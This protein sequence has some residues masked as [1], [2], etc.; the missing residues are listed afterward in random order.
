MT[1]SDLQLELEYW[2]ETGEFEED[3]LHEMK[4]QDNRIFLIEPKHGS[5]EPGGTR[6]VTMTYNHMLPG[7]DRLPVLLK[8]AAGREI[9]VSWQRA[10]RYW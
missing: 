7:T 10:G 6:A 3:E 9:L 1:P 8:L 5:L 2:A 4:V